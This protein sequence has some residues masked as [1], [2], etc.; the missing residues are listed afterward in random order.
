[1]MKNRSSDLTSII[2]GLSILL[3]FGTYAT[4]QTKS[5]IKKTNPKEKTVTKIAKGTF[6]VK[7]TPLAAEENVGDPLIGRLALEKQFS[8]ALTGTSKGQMLGI[9]TDLKDSGGYVAAERFTGTLDGKKGSFSLQH[10][11]TMQG[12]KF[13]L[14]VIVVPD[15]GTGELAGLTGKMN[16]IIKDGKHFYEF[17]YTMPKPK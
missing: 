9:G 2:L 14:N 4:A 15:S 6:E 10:S 8:G 12:G 16:I 11:G 17:E 5:H 7:V 1:M 13:V 3:Y